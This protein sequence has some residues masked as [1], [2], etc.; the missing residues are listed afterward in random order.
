MPIEL[1][2][3]TFTEQ[4]DFVG[5]SGEGEIL[6]NAFANTLA[7]NDLIVGNSENSYSDNTISSKGNRISGI[8]NSGT[9]N[10]DDGND[11]IIGTGEPT[12]LILGTWQNRISGIHNIGTL[13]TGDGDDKILGIR[14]YKIDE[15][16]NSDQL[17]YGIYNQEGTIDTGDGDDLIIGINEVRK[18]TGILLDNR[19]PYSNKNKASINTGNG[20]D[21]I[22]GIGNWSG[23]HLSSSGTISNGASIDTGNGNDIITGTGKHFGIDVAFKSG[24]DTEKGDDIITG[25]GSVGISIGFSS[26]I[27]TGDGND[28]ITTINST[29]GIKNNGT[30]NTGDGDDIISEFITNFGTIDT[31]NGN[32]SLISNKGFDGKG[33][34]FLGNGTDYLKGFGSGRFH[35]GDGE[36]TLEL[37]SGSYTIEI[38]ETAVK[39]TQSSNS[40]FKKPVIMETFEFE[41]LIAGSTTYDFT[42]LS[43]GQ[44]I[45]VA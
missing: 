10:T 32:D 24:I 4:G 17:G 28:T 25:N 43:N 12:D 38:S 2:G 37:T 39:F 40:P 41:K 5:L 20:N 19:N 33:D 11:L 13:N 31:G 22:T 42:S 36:D 6:N 44:T 21:T 35:G 9:F 29:W 23:I 1:S 7:G 34:I 16:L 18:A 8:Y 14:V 45:L 15:T 3:I 30:I 27:N 26:Y